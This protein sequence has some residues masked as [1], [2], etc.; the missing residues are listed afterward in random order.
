MSP[1]EPSPVREDAKAFLDYVRLERGLADNTEKS[2]RRDLQRFA[3]WVEGGGIRDYLNPGPDDLGRFPGYLKDHRLGAST[4]ARHVFTI[5]SFYKYL[6]LEQRTTNVRAELLE[7]PTV[8]KR[9]PA[10]LSKAGAERLLNAPQ[11]SDRFYLRDRALLEV[12]YATGGRVSEVVGLTVPALDL[13]R[14]RCRIRGKGSKERLAML[15]PRA[16][17]AVRAYLAV[18]PPSELPVFLSN[19]GGKSLNRI[20]I[21]MVIRKY[22]ERCKLDRAACH[23]H[24]LR[25]S[26]GTHML[27]AGA[28]VRAVQ[29]LLGHSSIDT[30]M[31]YTHVDAERLRTVHKKCHPRG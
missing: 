13:D 2:Y 7:S 22:G 9:L 29:T 5:R 17:A 12:L 25:H 31:Q 27:A 21:F 15:H 28:D 26:F 16:V 6:V 30:T 18:R 10:F 14:G 8:W 23:P 4:I 19:K 3:E 24:A 20:G 11:P 1:L